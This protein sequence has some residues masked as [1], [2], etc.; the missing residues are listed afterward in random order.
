M[1]AIIF[2]GLNTN[3]HTCEE[4]TGDVNG[5]RYTGFYFLHVN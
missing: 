4:L 3:D 1:S 2:K 5:L